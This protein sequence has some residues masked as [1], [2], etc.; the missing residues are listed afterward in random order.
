[1]PAPTGS[2]LKVN[3]RNVEEILGKDIEYFL[4]DFDPFWRDSIVTSQ[5][6]GSV[7]RIGRDMKILKTFGNPMGGVVEEE[8][9]YG[10]VSLY[11]DQT[12]TVGTR[13]QLQTLAQTFPNALEGPNM[14]TWEMGIPMRAMRTN[15][16]WTMGELQAEALPSFIREVIAPKLKGF[17]KL[18]AHTVCNKW[19]LNQN[20]F[21]AICSGSLSTVTFAQ[22]GGGTGGS[23]AVVGD[24]ISWKP[25]N[26][27]TDRFIIGQ[28]VDIYDSTGATRRNLDTQRVWL[29]VT[30]VDKLTNTVEFTVGGIDSGALTLTLNAWGIT[31]TDIVVYARSRSATSPNFTSI[32]GVNSWLKSGATTSANTQYLLGSERDTSAE[33]DLTL[34]PEFKSFTKSSVGN[35]T[36]HKLRQYLRGFHRAKMQDGQYIDCLVA[37][38]GVWLNYESQKIG[39]EILDRTG[40]TSNMNNEGSTEGFKF[41]FDGRTYNGYTSNYIESG[42]VYGLRKGG[43]N[44]KRYVPPAPKGAKTMDQMES[45]IPFKF[46]G[47]ILNGTESNQIP[48]QF[49]SGTYTQLSEGVQMPGIM[50][51]QLVPDQPAGLKLTGVTEDRVYSDN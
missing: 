1:M 42:S 32:A 12:T 41:T 13:L 29:Y 43:N 33:I 6:V 35:L 11:G 27:A 21:Y 20:E 15:I 49:S 23:V 25:S 36:E 48:I 30:K 9:P 37:S 2:F 14:K 18:L 47:S 4:S 26:Y 45:F 31:T 22:V 17:A 44:W 34:Y 16:M 40:R 5:G 3:E 51:M 50:R 10:D 38:D 28:R 7:N 46:V 24:K 39:R 19:Y 8:F